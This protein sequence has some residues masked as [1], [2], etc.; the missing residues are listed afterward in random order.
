MSTRL[1]FGKRCATTLHFQT[2]CAL[3]DFSQVVQ[4]QRVHILREI[5][6]LKWRIK[7]ST[8]NQIDCHQFIQSFENAEDAMRVLKYMDE[9]NIRANSVTYSLLLSVCTES[10]NLRLGEQ[11]CILSG[12][13]EITPSKF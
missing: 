7:N 9:K 3:E 6:S 1:W 13:N 5:S 12:F 10:R 4:R 11:V 2:N 8:L